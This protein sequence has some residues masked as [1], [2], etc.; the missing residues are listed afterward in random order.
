MD[1]RKLKLA[2]YGISANRYK[3]L[4]G[5]CEQYPEWKQKLRL[6]GTTVKSPRLT[7]M[8][9]A[10]K[11]SDS[12]GDLAV[13]R[14]EMERKC[15]L[16]EK[17]AEQA[18]RDLAPFIIKSVCYGQTLNHLIMIGEMPCSRTAFYDARRYFFYLL[19]QN[20]E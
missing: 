17:T 13:K 5:F 3:E 7:D 1:K 10:R 12:T 14:V 2:N 4:S 15:N 20:K 9:T 6:Q 18:S 19:D 16:I 11:L 8:P